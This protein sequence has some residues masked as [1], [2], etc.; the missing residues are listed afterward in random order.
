MGTPGPSRELEPLGSRSVPSSLTRPQLFRHWTRL[1][2]PKHSL[3][4][5]RTSTHGH[6]GT[7][8]R[9]HRFRRR[10][11]PQPRTRAW[12]VPMVL[13]HC[14]HCC[15]CRRCSSTRCHCS[16]TRC[17][18][19]LPASGIAVVF[20]WPGWSRPLHG[21]AHDGKH[22][23]KPQLAM[24]LCVCLLRPRDIPWSRPQQR[25][26]PHPRFGTSVRRCCVTVRVAEL[27]EATPTAPTAP[28]A[29]STY[30]RK[31]GV[32]WQ[33]LVVVFFCVRSAWADALTRD[34]QEEGQKE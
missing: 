24:S 26:T 4:Q 23:D 15:H 33:E 27:G 20:V 17:A 22:L 1:I 3:L 6:D 19:T 28:T 11:W 12:P 32:W 30:G 31:V 9:R 34:G 16:F 8:Q 21:L 25:P 13:A 7:D 18:S 14:C 5:D 2:P 29:R 10:A